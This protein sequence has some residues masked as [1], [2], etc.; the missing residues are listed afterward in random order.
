MKK[1]KRSGPGLKPG[2]NEADTSGVVNSVKGFVAFGRMKVSGNDPKR[3]S[4][5][6]GNSGKGK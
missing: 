4:N 6:S 2:V 1:F 5:V 3:N